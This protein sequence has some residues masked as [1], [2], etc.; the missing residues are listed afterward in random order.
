MSNEESKPVTV[1]YGS[2]SKAS[3]EMAEHKPRVEQVIDTATH[4]KKTVG[5]KFRETFVGEDA[6]SVG[7]YLIMDVVVPSMKNLISDMVREGI[8]RLLFGSSRPMGNVS[9]VMTGR[10]GYS[11]YFRPGTSRESATSSSWQPK[12]EVDPPQRTSIRDANNIVVETRG[13]AEVVMEA[14]ANTLSQ[15]GTV[16][17][18]DLYDIVGMTSEF[19]FNKYGWTDL[20][21]AEIRHVREGYLLALPPAQPLV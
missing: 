11:S 12:K 14:L 13:Q 18:A 1:K 4:R 16:T 19:T 5:E 3:K 7:G 20:T 21:H 17:V 10:S 15:Y 2:N 8:D 6:R 9:R